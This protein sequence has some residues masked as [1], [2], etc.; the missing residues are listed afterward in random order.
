MSS[1][2]ADVFWESKFANTLVPLFIFLLT[3]LAILVTTHLP[4]TD[5]PQHL[6]ITS[7][8]KNLQ[9][10]DYGFAPFYQ[11]EWTHTL[12]LFPYWLALFF[13]KFLPLELAMRCVITISVLLYPLGIFLILRAQKKPGIFAL[14]TLPL[15][16][17]RAFFWGFIHFN[18]SIGLALL[19]I[20]LLLLPKQN[21]GKHLLI[22]VLSIILV[23]THIYGLVFLF[24]FV[25]L[26][27]IVGERRQTLSYLKSLAPAV[28]GMG[29]W[30][31]L[32]L[33]ASSGYGKL[34]FISLWTRISQLGNSILGGYQDST[35][36]ALLVIWAGLLFLLCWKALPVTPKRWR[37]STPLHKV[38]CLYILLNIVLYMALPLQTF[39]IKM[40]YFRHAFLFACLLPLLCSVELW[41]SKRKLLGPALLLLALLSLGNTWFHLQAFDREANTFRRI[42]QALPQKPRVVSLIQH[43]HGKIMKTAPYAHFA[44]Y[45]QAQKGGL[46]AVSF[47]R[48]F[49]NIP[50]TMH[51]KHGIPKTPRDLEWLPQ[52]FNYK[53]FGYYYQYVIA[54]HTPRV[55]IPYSE[56]FPYKLQLGYGRWQLYRYVPFKEAFSSPKQTP[57]K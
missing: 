54:R 53:T 31:W 41:A 18:M 32:Q 14:L 13:A 26:N 27:G 50:V 46:I 7:I 25:F 15:L 51:P 16:F 12:Y 35:E 45:V 10:P 4:M 2:K 44:G 37:E 24:G 40:L 5:L 52:R 23:L 39:T 28:L 56:G 21:L 36:N 22:F 34:I 3:G 48:F 55:L 9:N 8:L 17:N 47:P 42:L 20:G 6:A 38:F 49:W 43:K 33:N 29:Y 30:F 11:I 1:S 19:I 57:K